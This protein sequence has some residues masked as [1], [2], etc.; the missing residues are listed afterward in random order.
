MIHDW[1][2]FDKSKQLEHLPFLISIF[3]NNLSVYFVDVFISNCV[4]F[5]EI[6][7]KEKLNI[8]HK[9]KKYVLPKN[10][11]ST[12]ITA[13]NKN[14]FNAEKQT[15]KTTNFLVCS[16]CIQTE[17]LVQ[18]LDFKTKT[19]HITN[20]TSFEQCQNN[21]LPCDIFNN[22]FLNDNQ[23]GLLKKIKPMR[24]SRKH[25]AEITYN[26]C[27]YIAGGLNEK[28]VV[29][30][31]VEKYDH[32]LKTWFSIKPMTI[33]RRNFSLVLHAGRI[34]AIAGIDDNLVLSSV[35]SYDF[36]KKT[37]QEEKSLND[38]RY[39]HAAIEFN[40]ELYVVGGLGQHNG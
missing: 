29:E 22:S 10:N 27:T 18:I 36:E 19:W 9:L 21:V 26:S 38:T 15:D 14:I 4:L 28:G 12:P 33:A 6:N 32:S 39:N 23:H 3:F 20:T 13:G 2:E 34:W 30:K 24:I 8:Y 17:N 11:Q 31:S 16:T 37:W 35:E 40:K 25:A 1:V 7:N 5:N